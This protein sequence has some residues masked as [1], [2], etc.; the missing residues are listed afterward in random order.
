MWGRLPLTSR[1]PAGRCGVQLRPAALTCCPKS[2]LNPW[3]SLDRM[4]N[5]GTCQGTCKVRAVISSRTSSVSTRQIHAPPLKSI[6]GALSDSRST[7]RISTPLKLLSTL[8]SDT[9]LRTMSVNDRR[10][11]VTLRDLIEW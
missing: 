2:R 11:C 5:K 3:D 6:Y 7:A 8:L 9:L 4:E 1:C 10:T